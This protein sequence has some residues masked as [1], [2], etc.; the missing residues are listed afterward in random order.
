VTRQFC[1]RCGTHVLGTKP[2][3]PG[4]VLI[5]VGTLDD[6][7]VFGGPEMIVFTIDRQ[8]FHHVPEGVAAF[9]RV[10]G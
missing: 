9:E 5:K 4:I 7:S 2:G 1:V 10:P 8:S 6:P 3:S